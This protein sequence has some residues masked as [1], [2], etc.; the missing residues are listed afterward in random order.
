MICPR[1]GLLLVGNEI[2]HLVVKK[3]FDNLMLNREVKK[4]VQGAC[5]RRHRRKEALNLGT[6][7]KKRRERG[8][9]TGTR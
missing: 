2:H 7:N 9:P 3:V 5:C 8:F 4:D 1:A 6:V